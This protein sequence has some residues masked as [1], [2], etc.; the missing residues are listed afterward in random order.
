[1]HDLL[2]GENDSNI[3]NYLKVDTATSTLLVSSTGVL[4]ADGS[5]AD[6]T[7]K[8]ENGS[9]AKLNLDSL[10]STSTDIINSLIAQDIVKID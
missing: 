1:M 2:Q 9:G 4:N 5:N 8:L 7:I 6:L 3:L 10:G